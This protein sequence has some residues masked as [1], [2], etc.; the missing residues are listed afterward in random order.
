M[1]NNKF[2]S[3]SLRQQFREGMILYAAANT[4]YPANM[5]MLRLCRQMSEEE[6]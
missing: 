5:T 1:K 6:N 4:G 3:Q 2:F